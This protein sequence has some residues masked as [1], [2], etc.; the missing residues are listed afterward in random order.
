MH[1]RKLGLKNAI[2]DF[3]YRK[4]EF[5]TALNNITFNINEGEIVGY[6]GPNG[7][8]KTTTL[9]ILS[10]ILYPT[11]GSLKVMGFIPQKREKDFLRNITFI[12]GQKGQLWWDLPPIETFVINKELYGISSVDFRNRLEELVEMFE[13]QDLIYIPV[14]KLSLGERMKMEIIASLLHRPKILFL[15]EPT[16]GLD[17][18]SQDSIRNFLIEYN[19]KYKATILLTSHYIKDIENMC[20]RIIILHQGR[21]IFDGDKTEIID[22]FQE[23]R[24]VRIRFRHYPSLKNAHLKY[25]LERNGKE[26]K[27]KAPS[28]TIT[29]LINKLSHYEEMEEVLVEEIDLEEAIKMVF[30]NEEIS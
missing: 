29:D 12:M 30:K 14:R 25:L 8:G 20:N 28:H 18:I 23:E 17:F 10:G 11:E 4:Y 5:V 26:Y 27:F 19:R 6:I 9:K 21:I 2:K 15:D 3:F 7:A 16:I 13:V 24:I 1:K 22:R